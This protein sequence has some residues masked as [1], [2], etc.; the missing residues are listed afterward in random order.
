M[1]LYNMTFNERVVELKVSNYDYKI[2]KLN[3]DVLKAF[4]KKDYNHIGLRIWEDGPYRFCAN[5]SN[6]LQSTH[7]IYTLYNKQTRKFSLIM[8][9]D[10]KFG[11]PE[12]NNIKFNKTPY[13]TNDN[14]FEK[15]NLLNHTYV[16]NPIGSVIRY[17]NPHPLKDHNEFIEL[18]QKYNGININHHIL[19]RLKKKYEYNKRYGFQQLIDSEQ[20]RIA[21]FQTEGPFFIYDKKDQKIGIYKDGF[22]EKLEFGDYVVAVKLL[23]DDE[24]SNKLINDQNKFN[25][26]MNMYNFYEKELR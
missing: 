26:F 19:N 5:D 16:Y 12:I 25:K 4:N 23:I 20:Y 9:Y 8:T 11:L 22:N 17:N 18:F 6:G 7:F 24:A 2:Y 13:L 10:T 14:L 15:C 3:S 1:H 21:K